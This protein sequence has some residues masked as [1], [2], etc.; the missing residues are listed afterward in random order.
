MSQ[1]ESRNALTTRKIMAAS[2]AYDF[3]ELFTYIHPDIVV[4]VPYHTPPIPEFQHGKEQ[5]VAG[6][7]FV[8]TM[9]KEF[10]LTI[11]ELY[12]L[13]E[14]DT[15]IFEMK[16]HGKFAAV[17]GIYENSYVMIFKF[18]DGLCIYWAERYD[19]D[20]FRQKML[21]VIAKMAADAAAG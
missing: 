4:H 1:P 16:S 10:K 18:R 6:M 20:I 19:S 21:P 13:P 5:F 15:V 3:E 2:S 17:D 14:R 8:P 7:G 11:T 9:F 12:D